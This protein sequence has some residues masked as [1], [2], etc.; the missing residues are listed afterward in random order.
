[1]DIHEY[2]L[3][4][5]VF[6]SLQYLDNFCAWQARKYRVRGQ[7]NWDHAIM[8]TGLNLYK[9]LG[10][11]KKNKKVLGLAWVSEWDD[12]FRDI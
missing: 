9:D 8:L 2:H 7:E 11:G 5:P 1:M 12:V 3:S 6:F 4:S 10:S